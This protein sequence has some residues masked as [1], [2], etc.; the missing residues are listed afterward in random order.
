MAVLRRHGDVSGF[1]QGQPGARRFGPH[2]EGARPGRGSPAVLVQGAR[3]GMTVLRRPLH[4]SNSCAG[5]ATSVPSG[6]SGVSVVT[7]GT[8]PLA[9]VL[10][11]GSEGSVSPGSVGSVGSVGSSVGSSESLGDGEP[12][13]E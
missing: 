6:L 13:A 9:E 10:V 5:Y 8:G 1:D 7:L 3:G 4:P 2:G 12:V 11:S